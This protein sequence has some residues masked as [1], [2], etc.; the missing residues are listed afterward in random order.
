MFKLF[1]S[2]WSVKSSASD[3]TVKLIVEKCSSDV[4]FAKFLLEKKDEIIRYLLSGTC[5][6]S[7]K[8]LVQIVNTAMKMAPSRDF[9]TAIM[10]HESLI[11]NWKQY[12]EIFQPVFYYVNEIDDKCEDILLSCIDVLT[13][14]LEGL[15][16]GKQREFDQCTQRIK[17]SYVFKIIL[18]LIVTKACSI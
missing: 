13:N 5:E 4:E 12:D 16:E 14:K 1:N 11:E 18:K 8:H 2:E 9:I 6:A 3:K 15:F 10:N 17:L 7:R